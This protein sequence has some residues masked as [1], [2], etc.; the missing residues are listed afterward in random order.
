ML[1]KPKPKRQMTPAAVQKLKKETRGVVGEVRQ[2]DAAVNQIIKSGVKE[3]G[4]FEVRFKTN[5]GGIVA[6]RYSGSGQKTGSQYVQKGR[7]AMEVERAMLTGKSFSSRT[8]IAIPADAWDRI[9]GNKSKA[10][11][12]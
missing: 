10:A 5:D 2:R 9:F 1:N 3:V 7:K 11:A 4:E 12:A 8:S 6:E